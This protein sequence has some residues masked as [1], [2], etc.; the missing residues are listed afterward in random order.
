MSLEKDITHINESINEAKCPACDK[1][2]F[3]RC[4]EN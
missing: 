3:R 1:E 2:M 4:L